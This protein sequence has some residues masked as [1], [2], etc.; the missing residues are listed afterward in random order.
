MRLDVV[1]RWWWEDKRNDVATKPTCLVS[2]QNVP[3][4]RVYEV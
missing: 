2:F 3:G 4:G 1:G